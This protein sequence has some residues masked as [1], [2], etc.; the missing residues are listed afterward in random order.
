VTGPRLAIVG[1]RRF[2]DPDAALPW[3]REK[4]IAAIGWLHPAVIISGGADG[5]DTLARAVAAEHGYTIQAG[6]FI[7]HLPTVL[8]WAAPGG[9]RDRNARIADDCTHLLALC[10]ARSRTHGT[11][12]TAREATRR[13]RTV[14]VRTHG[15]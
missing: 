10:C 6:T 5:I 8:A 2:A 14:W 11:A 12:W 15:E 1:S 13:G 4:I 7:E 9:F 3:A